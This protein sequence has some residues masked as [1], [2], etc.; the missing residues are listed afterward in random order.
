[1]ETGCSTRRVAPHL[2]H[3]DF[4]MTK[5]QNRGLLHG[6]QAQDTLDRPI[7]EIEVRTHSADRLIALHYHNGSTFTTAFCVSPYHLGFAIPCY[8]FN[9]RIS[10]LHYPNSGVPG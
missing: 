9:P 8:I 2:G 5:R 7:V 3:S 10:G 4:T 6:D 1:M